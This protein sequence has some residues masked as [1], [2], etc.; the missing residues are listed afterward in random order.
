MQYLKN[1]VSEEADFLQTDKHKSFL[2]IDAMFLVGNDHSQSTQNNKFAISLQYRKENGK[3]VVAFFL[4]DK[5]QNMI[6]SFYVCMTRH[7]QISQ[8]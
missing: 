6:L 7:I 5:H 8:N 1:E 3:N 4:A 2:Q